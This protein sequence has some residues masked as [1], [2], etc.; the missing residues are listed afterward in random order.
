MFKGETSDLDSSIFQLQE[1]SKDPTQYKKSKDALERYACKTYSSDMRTLFEKVMVL[2]KLDKPVKPGP[3][4]DEVDVEVFVQEKKHFAKETRTLAKELRAFF[5]VI[6]G[7]CSQNVR[8]K[9]QCFDDLEMWKQDGDCEKLL[10]AIEQVL[11]KYEHQKSPYLMLYRQQRVLMTNRQK[12][13]QS[14]SRYYD[15]FNTMIE[16]F[17]RFGGSVVQP[18][19]VKKIFEEENKGV[20]FNAD[21]EK[22]KAYNEKARDRYLALAFLLGGRSESFDDLITDLN[23]DFL[24]GRD[25][26]PK[27]LTEAFNLMSN[28]S[29]RKGLGVPRGVR[30]PNQNRPNIGFLQNA[31]KSPKATG[32]EVA[33]RDGK[34]FPGVECYRCGQYGHYSNQCPMSMYQQGH[35]GAAASLDRTYHREDPQDAHDIGNNGHDEDDNVGFAFLQ[36]ISFLQKGKIS[37]LSD[38]WI[39]LDTQSNCDIFCNKN[40]LHDVRKFNGPPL[41]LESNGGTLLTSHVGDI[42]NYGTVWFNPKSLANILSFSNVRKKFKVTMST[43]PKD[44]RP[45]IN[46]HKHN[47]QIMKFIEHPIGLYVHCVPD[48]T[49]RVDDN[50]ESSYAYSFLTT[51]SQ[52]EKQFTRRQ[53]QEARA[54]RALYINLGRPSKNQ[55]KQIIQSNSIL[56]SPVTIGHVMRAEYIYGHDVATLKGKTVRSQPNHVES[57]DISPVPTFVRTHHNNV[58][59]CVDLFFINGMAFFH[60]ISRGLQFRTVHDVPNRKYKTL[61]SCFQDVENLYTSRGFVITNMHADLEFECLKQSILPVQL[62][63]TSQGEHVPEVERSIRTLKDRCRT[64]IHSLPYKLYPRLLLRGLVYFAC[65]SVNWIPST[66]GISST[67]SPSTLVTG[68]QP[69]TYS[70]LNIT[71]GTYVQVHND[72]TITNTTMARTTGAIALY[73]NNRTTAWNFL[74]LATGSRITRRKWSVCVVSNDII[75]RI[76]SLA[77]EQPQTNVSENDDFS[78]SFNPTI[79]SVDT[80]EGADVA[81]PDISTHGHDGTQLTEIVDT[82]EQMENLNEAEESVLEEVLESVENPTQLENEGSQINTTENEN[83]S[84]IEIEEEIVNENEENIEKEIEENNDREMNELFNIHHAAEASNTDERSDEPAIVG[85]QRS[86]N[87]ANV[88]EERSDAFIANI[89]ESNAAMTTQINEQNEE[90]STMRRYNMRMNRKRTNEN[91]FNQKHYSFLNFYN[92]KK[93]MKTKKNYI[94]GIVYAMSNLNENGQCDETKL[95]SDVVGLCFTQMSAKKGIKMF[96]QEALKALADEYAQLDELAVFTPRDAS[97]LTRTEKRNALRTIDL[98][99]KKRCGK[100]KG[101]TVVDGRGQRNQ[102]N[103]ADTSSPAI[104]FESL[105]ATLVVDAYE[106]RD[107]A[108]SDVTGAFLKAKQ[109]DYVLLRLTGEAIDAIIKANPE[110]YE[111]HVVLEGNVRVLYLQLLRAMYGTLTAAIAWYTLFAETLMDMG[112]ILNPYDLCVA[113]KEIAGSQFTICWYVDDIKLSHRDQNEVSKMIRVLEGIFGTMNITRGAKHTYLGV[114]FTIRDGKVELIMPEYI[115]EC[116]NS[117]GEAINVN[118]ATPANKNLFEVN[119]ESKLLNTEKRITYHHIVQKLLHVCKR[120]RVDIQVAIAFMCTRVREPSEQ[121][122]AKLRRLLQYLRGTIKMKRIVSLKNFSE[123]EIYTDASHATHLDMRGHTGGCVVMGDGVLH[124]RSSKQRLNTKSSTETELVGGS[125]YLPYPVWLLYFYEAQ[126][127]RIAK[128]IMYQDNQSTMKFLM[129]GRKSCGKQ[130]RHVNIRFFWIA[131][132]LKTH[133]MEVEYC[134]TTAMIADFYSKPLQGGLFKRMRDVVMGLQ[135][136]SILYENKNKNNS[137]YDISLNDN[138]EHEKLKEDT[139][140]LTDRKERVG[141]NAVRVKEKMNRIDCVN[142]NDAVRKRSY[143]DI[144]RT[145]IMS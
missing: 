100:V 33:G 112:F 17:E 21:D 69:L 102:Y 133:N 132:R 105:I 119:D 140:A 48:T 30:I 2:P 8:T 36:H 91:T 52:L 31:K 95:Y 75:E 38:S 53:V 37:G 115:Q 130:S 137:E 88:G 40:L 89:D 144:A 94:N 84:D 18:F 23:N 76:H 5:S 46:V 90:S 47:G 4:A 68:S 10:E 12:E 80:I 77:K 108:T 56:G 44:T 86:D 85:D 111:K 72:L 120:A 114:D 65:M 113:N 82:T 92:H 16:G 98:I 27:D 101:R 134:P 104:T 142:V 138:V 125:D 62:H 24:K 39:L 141:K 26:F 50:L 7:Q 131:D 97:K 9:L 54:A 34:V 99:K 66:N 83:T 70:L 19:F 139:L 74:S 49:N 109:K 123:M 58:T 116:I 1:E 127:Y 81:E 67:I 42:P 143:A 43:G 136:V 45:T 11:M 87:V 63:L 25:Y 71:F 124:C 73:P 22:M 59:L 121:D 14:L 61:L 135:H 51:I 110:K 107:V 117:F 15:V 93:S 55:F 13:H 129:N 32:K 126:G 35:A 128:K 57:Y 78:L 6:Y 20:Q 64:I 29:M 103:K 60:T 106:N 145:N 28:W 122:W 118:A 41:R 3:G 79:P 96:G